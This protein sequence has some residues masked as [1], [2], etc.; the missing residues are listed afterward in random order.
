MTVRHEIRLALRKYLHVDMIRCRPE[1]DSVSMIIAQMKHLRINLVVDVGANEGQYGDDLRRSGYDGDIWS[2]EPLTI[3]FEALRSK[4]AKDEKRACFQCAAG[5]LSGIQEINVAGNVT[6]SSFLPMLKKHAES[7]PQSQYTGI[8]KVR[9][10]PLDELLKNTTDQ[11][12]IWLKLDVQGYE[13]RVL[14]G[15]VNKLKEIVAVQMELSLTP[16]YA[17]QPDM[18]NMLRSMR[19]QGFELAGVIAGFTDPKSGQM[20]QSDAIFWNKQKAT[21]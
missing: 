1:T 13:Q 5:D 4:C 3:P 16:L 18:I 14:A 10:E 9:I 20:L 2:Y 15:A 17:D 8:E 19:E 12:R 21:I 6:S 11:N 7:A